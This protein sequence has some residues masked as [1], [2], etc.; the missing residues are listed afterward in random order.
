MY[1][2]LLIRLRPS[3]PWRFGSGEGGLDRV[4]ALYR[5]DRLFSAVTI[6]MRRLGFIE[7][8]LDATARS[9]SPAAAFTSLFPCQGDTLFAIPP[10]TVWPPPASLVNAPSPVFLAKIRWKTARFVPLTLIDSLVTGGSVLA[11]QW[12]PDVESG[13]LLRRD[14]PNISPFRV[15]LRRS[16]VVDRVTGL[17]PAVSGVA[18][19]EFE[20][21]AG[22]WTV[23]RYKDR[24]SQAN[25]NERLEAAFRLL[26]D[27]GFG[28]RRTSGW[29]HSEQPGFQRGA[30][31]NLLL[32]K[33]SR[34]EANGAGTANGAA[35]EHSRYWLLSL[36]SP[37]PDDRVDWSGGEYEVMT[38]A[39][40]VESLAAGGQEKKSV[41][42][43]AEGSVLLAAA[44]PVGT[45]LDVAPEGSEHPVYRS[46]I[47]VAL[48]L[49]M[50]GEQ[51]QSE[52][53]LELKSAEEPATE[54]AIVE[55]P[56]A[57]DEP[58]VSEPVESEPELA[59]AETGDA[60]PSADSLISEEKRPEEPNPEEPNSEPSPEEPGNAL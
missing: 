23:V 59:I 60:E 38:R 41:R 56:C 16:A 42:M 55:R 44:D 32:P 27:S 53:E 57:A 6:A 2:A 11:D 51:T 9:S 31:P 45:A 47:A 21:G 19:L 37:S 8:W 5:S 29:G 20:P 25:W 36:Y 13:C 12:L 35:A 22:L 33:M 54:E 28:G 43:I 15:T 49:P 58:G 40:W 30:W 10:A 7:E 34:A 17:A 48:R 39:G 26:A 4:D 24:A 46:G 18:A 50:A 1:P 14:R 52:I 3:G